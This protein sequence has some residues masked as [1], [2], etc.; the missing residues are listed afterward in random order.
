MVANR[1]CRGE[2]AFGPGG[3]GGLPPGAGSGRGVAERRLGLR[4]RAVRAFWGKHCR[5]FSAWWIP[6]PL[7][8]M[9]GAT[10]RPR[11]LRTPTKRSS[12]GAPKARSRTG[13][14]GGKARN[15][16]NCRG[17]PTGRTDEERGVW[18][19]ACPCGHGGPAASPSS[20]PPPVCAAGGGSTWHCGW[21]SAPDRAGARGRMGRGVW[22]MAGPCG[23][24]EQ[25]AP[26]S[27]RPPPLSRRPAAG[28]MTA[29]VLGPAR[30]RKWT[31]LLLKQAAVCTTAPWARTASATVGPSLG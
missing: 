3:W 1:G 14:G 8:P 17:W 18:P 24:G 4:P 2:D 7:G 28:S 13:G 19:M 30:R 25:A 26:P 21:Q 16:C 22:P 10:G 23:Q 27:S 9:D 6:G 5:W 11:R 20:R 12:T 29:T 31:R 15:R